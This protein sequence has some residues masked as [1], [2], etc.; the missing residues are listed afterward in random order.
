MPHHLLGAVELAA[1]REHA[2]GTF[3]ETIEQTLQTLYIQTGEDK[4]RLGAHDP[5]RLL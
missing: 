4:G 1:E 3:V 5:V 2:R